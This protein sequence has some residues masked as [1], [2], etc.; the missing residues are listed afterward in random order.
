MISY[1]RSSKFLLRAYGE[2]NTFTLARFSNADVVVPVL[3]EKRNLA[4]NENDI[5]TTDAIVM[6][7]EE[8]VA[9]NISEKKPLLRVW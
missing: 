4:G 3:L 6:V 9:K 8:H 5:F 2:E 1:E 7:V